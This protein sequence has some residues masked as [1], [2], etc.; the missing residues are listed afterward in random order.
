MANKKVYILISNDWARGGKSRVYDSFDKARAVMDKE[1][2]SHLKKQ[3]GWEVDYHKWDCARI[4][5]LTAFFDKND[6][7]EIVEGKMMF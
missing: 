5:L 3:S 6:S 1:V 2:K 7:W 4:H